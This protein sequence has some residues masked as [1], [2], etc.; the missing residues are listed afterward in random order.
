MSYGARLVLMNTIHTSLPM[1]MLSFFEIQKWVR[2]RLDY[3][4]SRFFWQCDEHKWKFWL[5]RWDIICR[6]KDLEGLGAEDL[7]IKHKCFFSKCLFK[8]LIEDMVWQELL[9]NKYLN[10][11][12]LSQVTAKL[13]GSLFWKGLLRVKKGFFRRVSFLVGNGLTTRFFQDTLAGGHAPG[14]SIPKPIQHC[15]AERCFYCI[16]VGVCPGEY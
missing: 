5:T 3:Y 4:R 14:H 12:T 6:P 2:K 16:S 1:F 9:R 8:L 13:T 10:S 11:K 15:S 7:E